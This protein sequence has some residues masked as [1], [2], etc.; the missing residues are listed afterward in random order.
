MVSSVFLPQRETY[1]SHKHGQNNSSRERFCALFLRNVLHFIILHSLLWKHLQCQTELNR[2]QWIT[3]AK[4]FGRSEERVNILV[5]LSLLSQNGA[6][7]IFK[8]MT[9]LCCTALSVLYS[10]TGSGAS[11]AAVE[12]LLV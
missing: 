4:Q 1:I 7:S 2:K 6:T 11:D 12:N 5:V 10:T 3:E 9:K 8:E